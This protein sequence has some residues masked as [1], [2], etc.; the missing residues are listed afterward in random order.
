MLTWEEI[1]TKEDPNGK[2][3]DLRLIC[4]ICEGISTCRCSKPKRE[5]R[6][7]CPLCAAKKRL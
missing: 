3:H 6:G 1:R 7:I 4:T 2:N 5:F